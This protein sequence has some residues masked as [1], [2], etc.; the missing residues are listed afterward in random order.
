VTAGCLVDC[1]GRTDAEAASDRV[2]DASKKDL[3]PP[4]A[5]GQLWRASELRGVPDATSKR[6]NERS[7][8]IKEW[9]KKV[10]F[11]V[12]Y[13]SRFLRNRRPRVVLLDSDLARPIPAESVRHHDHDAALLAT[14]TSALARDLGRAVTSMQTRRRARTIGAAGAPLLLSKRLLGLLHRD[15][16]RKCGIVQKHQCRAAWR[17]R[18]FGSCR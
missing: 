11:R 6:F 2:R 3:K 12:Y 7:R 17:W 1:S 15:D 8:F 9:S 18:G 13:H 16:Q 5:A 14:R 4:A 10:L